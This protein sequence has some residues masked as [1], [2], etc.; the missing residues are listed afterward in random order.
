MQIAGTDASS[1]PVAV[2]AD[3]S[4]RSVALRAGALERLD[5]ADMS[6][7]E[8]VEAVAGWQQIMSA[9]LARQG[10]VIRELAARS[11]GTAGGLYLP[12]ELACALATTRHA[13]EFAVHQA[14]ALGTHPA[15]HDALVD[16]RID[17][18]KVTAVL[19]ELPGSL[20][21]DVRRQ[22]VLDAVAHA[23]D[24]TAP[25][26]RRHVRRTVLLACPREVEARTARARQD[27]HV[28]LEWGDD[29]MAW[30]S[31]YLPAPDAVAVYTVVD[32]LA[33]TSAP[34]DDDRH[35]DQR[36]ADAFADVFRRILDSQDVPGV[37]PLPR[38]HGRRAA[39]QVTVAA[40][41]LLGVDDAP[42]E[43]GSYGPIPASMAREIAQDA[44][45]TRV[46]TD[47]AT[48][49]AVEAGA[50]T[51]RPGADLTRT[52]IARDVTCTFFGCRQP[53]ARCDLDHVVPFHG[54]GHAQPQTTAANLHA[55]C[56]RHHQAKTHGNWSVGR[57]PTTGSTWWTSPL[58]ITTIRP[59]VRLV[60]SPQLLDPHAPR[61]PPPTRSHT[62]PPPGEP[63]F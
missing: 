2:S 20:S 8:L 62:R 63:P 12:E 17:A 13:A 53:A 55:L 14:V 61:T 50:S 35:V 29:A 7:V 59:A 37:G 42:A 11:A 41:T 43:L 26:L 27:R 6:D 52:V 38:R 23:R 33:G 54:S 51:Y 39:V 48:G 49:T 34:S 16:G 28:R 4:S 57:D 18:R 15:L 44:T 21:D 31:A 40:T 10:E 36:R 32:A 24:L 47:P 45:W 3:A 46:L 30:V 1:R 19:D 5:L 22:V 9:A 58:G 56:R 25:Q 60:A